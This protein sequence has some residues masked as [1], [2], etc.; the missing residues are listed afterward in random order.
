[1]A[2][3]VA[4]HEHA[5]IETLTLANGPADRPDSLEAEAIAPPKGGPVVDQSS[6]RKQQSLQDDT[7]LVD[8][9]APLEVSLAQS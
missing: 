5:N 9:S 2:S 7:E 1:M 6:V 4:E 3:R 8:G